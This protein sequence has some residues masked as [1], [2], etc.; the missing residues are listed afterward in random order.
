MRS[1]IVSD[2]SSYK[3]NKHL[4]DN[5]RNFLSERVAW[6]VVDDIHS[7]L[8][9]YE[10]T[11]LDWK[12]AKKAPTSPTSPS[13][14]SPPVP[15][16][17]TP[18]TPPTIPGSLPGSTPHSLPGPDDSA[19]VV[20]AGTPILPTTTSTYSVAKFIQAFHLVISGRSLQNIPPEEDPGSE[21]VR[22]AT[23]II[24]KLEKDPTGKTLDPAEKP[25]Y[26]TTMGALL[27]SVTQ[28]ST[29]GLEKGLK[30]IGVPRTKR[31]VGLL[32]RVLGFTG[33][34]SWDRL[35]MRPE[36]MEEIIA[37]RSPDPKGAN[38]SSLGRFYSQIGVLF[39]ALGGTLK[40]PA[41]RIMIGT[42]IKHYW[43]FILGNE[44]PK[45]IHHTIIR[46]NFE[47]LAKYEIAWANSIA[48]GS[49]PP[50]NPTVT[51]EKTTRER[52]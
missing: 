45:H 27:A 28:G 32:D 51:P 8:T 39:N 5:W 12:P 47:E 22:L 40:V 2:W 48:R 23:D 7:W 31:I 11:P 13:T 37:G 46:K 4:M 41:H 33:G 10:P 26:T 43:E 29:E 15:V 6:N 18:G 35:M 19:K 17:T 50:P 14:P 16:P 44:N 20:P 1:W 42:L 21:M 30:T 3:E 49:S 34:E 9:D 24:R 52:T 38:L 25:Y 36:A